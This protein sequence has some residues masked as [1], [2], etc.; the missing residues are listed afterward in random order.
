MTTYVY[1]R[2]RLVEKHLAEPLDRVHVISDTMNPTRNH[3]D[4]RVYDSKAKF[5]SATKAMGCIEIGNERPGKP[6]QP[7]KLDRRER[8]EHIKRA[9]YELRNR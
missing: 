3:A 4:G 7:I 6:R 8:R 2:G 9:I 5:R 1:R